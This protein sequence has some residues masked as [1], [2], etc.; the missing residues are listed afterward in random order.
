MPAPGSEGIWLWLGTAGMFLGMLYFIARGWGETDSRR[1]K[2]YIATIVN[3]P[4][5]P[6]SGL[7]GPRLLRSGLPVSVSE[8][9]GTS[10]TAV[11]DSAGDFPLQ[12]VWSVPLL[13]VGYS[14]TTDDARFLSRLNTV[15]SVVSIVL[16]RSTAGVVRFR[17]GV[18]VKR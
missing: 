5:L 4:D 1:Q 16:P 7:P 8:L 18:K 6:R 14:T 17:R 15:G 10:P 9:A 12:E 13:P 11:P 3:Y 2:F